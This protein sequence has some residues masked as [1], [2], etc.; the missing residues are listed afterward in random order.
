MMSKRNFY[1]VASATLATVFLTACGSFGT[2]GK[3]TDYRSQ[4]G[5]IASLEVSSRPPI[6]DCAWQ[7]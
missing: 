2:A 4:G 5:K 3:S 6:F 7:E 1:V